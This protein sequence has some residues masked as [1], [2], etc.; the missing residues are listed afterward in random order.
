MAVKG[1]PLVRLAQT[2]G[3]YEDPGMLVPGPMIVDKIQG[4]TIKV[5]VLLQGGGPELRG[6]TGI[7]YQKRSA[8]NFY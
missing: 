8:E 4:K 6:H 2:Q 1:E 7:I 5:T 3:L